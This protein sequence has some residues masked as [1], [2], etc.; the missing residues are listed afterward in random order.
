MPSVLTKHWYKSVASPVQGILQSLENL[1]HCTVE[2]GGGGGGG[3]QEIH[4]QQLMCTHSYKVH[5]KFPRTRRE[6]V[7]QISAK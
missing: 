4:T 5:I 2:E 1:E 7:C 6:V 3:G